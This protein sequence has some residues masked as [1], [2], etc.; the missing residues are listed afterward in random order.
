MGVEI[1]GLL[2]LVVLV[3][4]VWAIIQIFQ[5]RATTGMKVFWIVLILLL[6]LLGLVLWFF[7]GPRSARL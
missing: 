1:G 2:G 7:V 4:S 6:P 3:A 5:S